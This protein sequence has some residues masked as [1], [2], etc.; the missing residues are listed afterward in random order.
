MSIAIKVENVSKLYRLGVIG[1]GTLSNDIKRWYIR[2][3]GKEDPFLKIGET[4]DRT[5][6]GESN[7]IWSLK[8]INFEIEHY[9]QK[10]RFSF[11]LHTLKFNMLHLCAAH[12]SVAH[13]TTKICRNVFANHIRFAPTATCFE[14]DI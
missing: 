8:D 12:N 7:V 9:F 4:N 3:R 1:T 5:I 14:I 11:L 10:L 13:S 2:V 6:K